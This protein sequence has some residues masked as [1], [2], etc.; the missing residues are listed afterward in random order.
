MT[1]EELEAFSTEI[2]ELFLKGDIKCPVHLGGG[3]ETDL[4]E[5]FKEVKPNDWILGTW[6]SHWLWLLSG[7]SRD[8]LKRQIL[9]GHSMH[10]FGTKFFTSAIV[11][12]IAP[13]AVGLAK[14]LK[15]QNSTDKV[16]CFLGDMGASCGI[17]IESM[18]YA[19]GHQLPVNFIVE[20]NGLSVRTDTQESWGCKD[21]VFE[22]CHLIG[23][24]VDFFKYIR[25][26]NH[27]GP[28]PSGDTRR[29]LF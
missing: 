1:K 3:N 9:S 19:C 8:E 18:R 27:A 23:K 25:K 17:A 16:W 28:Y 7:R 22:N 21:C 13:I 20:D 2:G 12:G 24:K 5:I 11:G 4:I 14:A 6:R 29:V 15:L 10:V 26:Y